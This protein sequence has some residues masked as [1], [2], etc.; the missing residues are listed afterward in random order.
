MFAAHAEVHEATLLGEL[1]IDI[2]NFGHEDVGVFPGNDVAGSRDT[3]VDDGVL[4]LH[5]A[6][7]QNIEQ[8]RVQRPSINLENEIGNPGPYKKRVHERLIPLG[9]PLLG[10]HVG[11]ANVA[12]RLN[13][14]IQPDYKSDVAE[15]QPELSTCEACEIG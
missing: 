10:N 11:R 2:G 8:L 13:T 15:P 5:T 7:S 1:L 3:D 4:V 14:S 12:P 6:L 9:G